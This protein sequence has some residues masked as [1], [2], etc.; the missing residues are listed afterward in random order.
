MNKIRLVMAIALAAM[1][2]ISCTGGP[3]SAP[4]ATIPSRS[5]ADPVTPSLPDP[6]PQPPL[7]S[8]SPGSIRG[9]VGVVLAEGAAPEPLPQVFVYLK[10][11]LEGKTFPLPRDPVVLDQVGFQFI[12]HVFGLR[13]GQVLKITSQDPSQHNVYCS[14]FKNPAF[15]ESLLSGDVIEKKFTA[16]EIMVLFQCHIHHIMKAYAGVLD[17]PFFAVTQVDGTFEIPGVPPGQYTVAFWEERLGSQ[18]ARVELGPGEGKSIT[19]TFK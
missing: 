18:T 5:P 1:L 10:S 12:P 3:P 13:V 17:H 19:I 6:P 11:G 14:P 7:A 8:R 9:R 4:E 16:P 2:D 15:N